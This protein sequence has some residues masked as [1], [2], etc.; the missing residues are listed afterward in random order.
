MLW[1]LS[2]VLATTRQV[3]GLTTVD[4]PITIG[5]HG[6][7]RLSSPD[8]TLYK[9][10][11][12]SW[13][14]AFMVKHELSPANKIPVHLW[15]DSVSFENHLKELHHTLTALE[16]YVAVTMDMYP[17]LAV[18]VRFSHGIAESYLWQSKECLIRT[19]CRYI[20]F[21]VWPPLTAL[22]HTRYCLFRLR[23]P[24]WP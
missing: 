8:A 12:V 9:L 22:V 15:V 2:L 4:V 7:F 6:G 1:I 24:Q 11:L 18:N 14:E 19:D 3:V 23:A 13:V 16:S 20:V 17:F 21:L 10:N 5:V